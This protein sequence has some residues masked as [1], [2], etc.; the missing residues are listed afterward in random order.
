MKTESTKHTPG[1]WFHD[2][3]D[4]HYVV[5]GRGHIYICRADDG[6]DDD[7]GTA[8]GRYGTEEEVEA[9][10][11][12]IAAAPELLTACRLAGEKLSSVTQPG[13]SGWDAVSAC[14]DA[15]NKAE[16]DCWRRSRRADPKVYVAD[17][18][19]CH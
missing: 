13:E 16:G 11:R 17:D 10:A 18:G 7:E 1:P 19:T 6:R 3:F 9:N 14:R 2:D 4:R 12:L 8:E 15:I 5:A